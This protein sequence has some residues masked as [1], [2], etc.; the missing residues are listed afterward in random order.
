MRIGQILLE[1]NLVNMEAMTDRMKYYADQITSAEGKAYFQKTLR[2]QI[3]NG[4]VS[5]L[6]N[7]SQQ[8]LSSETSNATHGQ[9]TRQVEPWAVEAAKKGELFRFHPTEESEAAIDHIIHWIKDMEENRDTRGLSKIGRMSFV[10]AITASQDYF[11]KTKKEIA[12]IGINY[13]GRELVFNTTDGFAWYLLKELNAYKEEGAFLNNCIGTFYKPDQYNFIYVMKDKNGMS[14]VAARIARGELVEVRGKNNRQ[15]ISKYHNGTVEFL[16][17]MYHDD[18]INMSNYDLGQ[19]GIRVYNGQFLDSREY[20]QQLKLDMSGDMDVIYLQDQNE[21]TNGEVTDN[22]KSLTPELA[23]DVWKTPRDRRNFDDAQQAEFINE[24]LT[25]ITDNDMLNN[26]MRL[27]NANT[28]PTNDPYRAISRYGSKTF[29]F[30]GKFYS[31]ETFVKTNTNDAIIDLFDR[32]SEISQDLYKAYHKFKRSPPPE[33]E[34]AAIL[35]KPDLIKYA[36]NPNDELQLKAVNKKGTAI[37]HIKNPSEQI[38]QAAV[39]QDG[40]AIKYI[41]NPSKEIQ[42]TAVKSYPMLITE[43]ENPDDDISKAAIDSGM[44]IIAEMPN[45]S[46]EIQLYAIKSDPASVFFIYN[47]SNQNQR[48]IIKHAPDYIGY[49]TAHSRDTQL[50]MIKTAPE[51]LEKINDPIP[52]V[53]EYI[54]NNR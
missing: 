11:R 26:A 36:T 5:E 47:L 39:T 52:E 1:Y 40:N 24:F 48:Y 20:T 27:L 28:V 2:K 35:K 30:N 31:P 18:E 21:I 37:E 17:K 12:A 33:L 25:G 50:F 38:K 42:M 51:Y 13:E 53:K 14:H 4:A 54:R 32:Q 8:F 46:D 43:I 23:V 16:R 6:V 15:P 7:V 10:N 29:S 45:A 3:I 34:E 22:V 9:F 44:H 19:F 49:L 41:K